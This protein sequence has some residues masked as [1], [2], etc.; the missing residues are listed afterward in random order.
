MTGGG[1]HRPATALAVLGVV[2]LAAAALMELADAWPH[3]E[4]W[5]GAA[6]AA[7]LLLTVPLHRGD[8]PEALV[9]RARLLLGGGVAAVFSVVGLWQVTEKSEPRVLLLLAP[10]GLLLVTAALA[11]REAGRSA[12]ALRAARLRARI[13]GE[14]A[15]RRRWARELHDETL[16]DLAAVE[17]TL[18][19]LERR[20]S[21]GGGAGA[22][23]ARPAARPGDIADDIAEVRD[24]V[25][26][27]IGALRHL[28]TQMRPIAL[29]L[30][31]LGPALEDL[32]RRAGEVGD[33]TGTCDVDDLPELR[34]EAALAVYRVV[35]EAVSNAV[36]HSGGTTVA[37][38]A[39]VAGDRLRVRVADDGA[40][41]LGPV[42]W[43]AT[44]PA[45]DGVPSGGRGLGVPGMAERAVALGGRVTW[46][47]AAGG[48]TVVDLD[49]PLSGVRAGSQR[50]DRAGAALPGWRRR[51]AGGPGGSAAGPAVGSAGG[52]GEPAGRVGDDLADDGQRRPAD[53]GLA[54]ETGDDDPR[55][56]P[57]GG[58]HAPGELGL[59]RPAQPR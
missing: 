30:L 56:G 47:A 50:A 23:P 24:A 31:G 40:G 36:R 44:A 13:E 16:Q 20:Y 1:R 32:V 5:V 9:R 14:E 3:V 19:R 37:V 26:D 42:P 55:R 12:D 54:T 11:V 46:S 17:V 8:S 27:R 4:M 18:G 35:Q 51:P 7:V 52:A 49:L 6:S 33:L 59:D 53:G 22:A 10:A 2:L 34:P 58:E 29:D 38:T 41:I 15:E 21:A 39:R 48:G 57:R 28:I 45:P 25:R 43:D